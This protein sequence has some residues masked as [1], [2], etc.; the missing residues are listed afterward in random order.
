[1]SAIA[2]VG[3]KINC[4][5]FCQPWR[6]CPSAQKHAI[7]MV[8]GATILMSASCLRRLFAGTSTRGSTRRP[9]KPAFH[10]A[11]SSVPWRTCGESIATSHGDEKAGEIQSQAGGTDHCFFS[12]LS[13]PLSISRTQLPRDDMKRGAQVSGLGAQGDQSRHVRNPA[14]NRQPDSHLPPVALGCNLQPREQ[15]V[16]ESPCA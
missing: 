10:R 4:C 15:S 14:R 5:S 1:M 6:C 11:Q 8:G 7:I 2:R 12:L 16:P 9:C 13:R 3:F